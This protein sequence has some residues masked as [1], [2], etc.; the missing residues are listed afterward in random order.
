MVWASNKN[1]RAVANRLHT[2]FKLSSQGE[3]LGL[4]RPDGATVEH[5]YSPAYPA[6]FP[7]GTYGRAPITSTT[8]LLAETSAGKARV[9]LANT[10][11]KRLFM[12]GNPR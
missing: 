11:R 6:Q 4:V 7:N 12:A 2:N 3:F 10:E 9:A 5:S 8:I 1:R